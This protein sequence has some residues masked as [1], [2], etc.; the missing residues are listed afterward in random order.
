MKYLVLILSLV[1]TVSGWFCQNISGTADLVLLNGK[2]YTVSDP[3]TIFEAIAVQDDKILSVG[4]NEQIKIYTGQKTKVIDLN[5]KPVYPG[6]IESHA[7]FMKLGYFKMKLDLKKTKN[8]TEIITL[9]KSAV[10]DSK[11]GEWIEGRGWHQEKW[12]R[13][14]DPMIEGYP[15]HNKLSEISPDNPVYLKHTSGHAIIA[16]KIAMDLTGIKRD[17]PDPLGG[18]IIRDDAGN[19]TGIFLE[20]AEDTIYNK[21]KETEELEDPDIIERKKRQAF[22]LASQNCIEN[23]ITSFHDAGVSF[24]NIKFFKDMVDEKR[25]PIRLWVMISEINDSLQHKLGDYKIINYGDHRLTVRAI[26]RYMDGALGARGAWLL[27]PYTDLPGTAG[28]A[29]KP[30]ADL[31]KTAQLA[32]NHGF[33]IC[34]HSIGD[35]GNRETLNLYQ[36]I[37]KTHPDKKNLRWRIEHAQHLH[38]DDIPRFKELNVIAAMQSNHCISDGPWVPKR[39]GEKRSQ[40]GA[41]VWRDLLKSGAVI[42]NGTDAPVE[43]VNPLTNFHAAITRQ[44]PDGSFFYPE[45][46]MTRTESLKSYT[47][48]GAYAAFEEDIKGT[49]EPGK[50][51]DLV[52]LSKDIM[53]IT[54]EEIL[55]TEVIYTIIGGDIVYH[56][57]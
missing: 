7:H 46:S 2:I 57:E 6:F 44:L 35:R 16:N 24:K 38:Q 49:I 27:E 36:E 15:V 10:A 21:L 22:R 50:L 41:Y 34:T 40:S 51:A 39:I 1:F 55:T 43:D 23:G 12:D 28:L 8:W 25:S 48:N 13:L 29:T 5:Q 54:A 33:Q 45:Q 18:R 11:P 52:V 26:K 20:T 56:K 42:C 19:P 53:I 31:K 32:I 47:I 30:L 9:V 17:T 37:F 3:D 14:P 4:S